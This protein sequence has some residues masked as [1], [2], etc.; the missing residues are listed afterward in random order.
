M[1]KLERLAPGGFANADIPQGFENPRSRLTDAA[2]SRRGRFIYY[3]VL[4]V[5]ILGGVVLI[6]LAASS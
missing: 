1:K 6:W 3:S 4:A 5:V 2:L